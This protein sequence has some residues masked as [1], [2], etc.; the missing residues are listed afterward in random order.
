MVAEF[1]VSAALAER[2][3]ARC[4]IGIAGEQRVGV[5]HLQHRA[6]PFRNSTQANHPALRISNLEIGSEVEWPT[7]CN[8]RRDVVQLFELYAQRRARQW[9]TPPIAGVA[10]QYPL[11]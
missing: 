10:L 6:D 11:Q 9:I 8:N 5:G 2:F 7:Q 3:H 1:A 4:A